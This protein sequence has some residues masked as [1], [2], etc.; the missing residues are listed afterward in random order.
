MGRC[1]EYIHCP[2]ISLSLTDF[3][4]EPGFISDEA[5]LTTVIELLKSTNVLV[6]CCGD[7]LWLLQYCHFE[8]DLKHLNLFY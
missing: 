1:G 3:Q 4:N 2:E 5:F 6:F 7:D 8:L